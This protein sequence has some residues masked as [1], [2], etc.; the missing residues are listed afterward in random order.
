M[1]RDPVSSRHLEDAQ[2]VRYIDHEASGDERQRW[3]DHMASCPRCRTDVESLRQQSATI[4]EWLARADFDRGI[5]RGQAVSAAEPEAAAARPRPG[6]GRRDDSDRSLAGRARLPLADA[7]PWLKAAAIVLLVAAPLVAIPPARDWVAD[8]LGLAGGDPV[9]LPHTT[10]VLGEMDADALVRFAPAPG[11]FHISVTA[12][13]ARGSITLGRVGPGEEAVFER[14][15]DAPRP[16]VVVSARA[17]RIENDPSATAS[18]TLLLPPEVTA[19]GVSVGT[20]QIDFSGRDID[21]RTVVP[22]DR[23]RE[24]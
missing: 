21:R 19:V 24:R 11:S 18:Y 15:G 9:V 6:S 5:A 4:T 8:R 20:H 3:E 22:L 12:A 1:R 23:F 13:Q 14:S 2:L 17:I 16:E 10:G 7:A